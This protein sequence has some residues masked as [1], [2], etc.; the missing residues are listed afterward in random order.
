MYLL[1]IEKKYFDIVIVNVFCTINMYNINNRLGLTSH[2]TLLVCR[3]Q[4]IR[5]FGTIYYLL[6]YVNTI[7]FYIYTPF[8]SKVNLVKIKQSINNILVHRWR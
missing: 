2:M 3:V 6:N 4:P 7:T 5:S 1:E 8:H